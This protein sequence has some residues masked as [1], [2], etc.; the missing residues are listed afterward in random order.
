MLVFIEQLLSIY[1][2]SR[3]NVASAEH[4]GDFFYALLL[5]EFLHVRKSSLFGFFFQNLV[6]MGSHGSNLRQVGDG[7]NVD[8]SRLP[9]SVM[10]SA[11]FSAVLPLTPVS[12]SSKMMVGSFTAPLIMRLQRKH[13]A[14]DFSTRSNLTHRLEKRALIGAEQEIYLVNTIRTERL[15]GE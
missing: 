6:M 4:L 11:I 5:V 8:G 9:I 14:G 13:D 3:R 1:Q 7:N 12:I 10:I 2:G 15:G